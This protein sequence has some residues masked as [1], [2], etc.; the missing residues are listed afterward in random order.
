M[1]AS[2]ALALEFTA[3]ALAS[4]PENCLLVHSLSIQ[5]DSIGDQVDSISRAAHRNG[6]ER[7]RCG[8]QRTRRPI[9][10]ARSRKRCA[11]R[12]I[13]P[14]DPGFGAPVLICGLLKIGRSGPDETS[15]ALN[16]KSE[17]SLSLL[18]VRCED[19]CTP[20]RPRYT[21]GCIKGDPVANL[22]G[23]AAEERR[24]RGAPRW[25]RGEKERGGWCGRSGRR[26]E[27]TEDGRSRL[28][29]GSGAASRPC[30]P[31]GCPPR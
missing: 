7:A 18:R 19:R 9:G 4:S 15:S 23:R 24:G 27:G 16:S 29:A 20:R 8:I 22:V 26:S 11:R 13:S 21:Q 6:I 28:A 25:G 14:L 1:E 12:R 30:C 5:P 3:L 31:G 2:S 17:R 10:C